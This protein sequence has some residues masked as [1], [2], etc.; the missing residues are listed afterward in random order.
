MPTFCCRRG[1]AAVTT[2]SLLTFLETA[3]SAESPTAP[4]PDTNVSVQSAGGAVRLPPIE[5]QSPEAAPSLISTPLNSNTLTSQQISSWRRQ[6]NDTAR[7]L[8]SVAGASVYSAG[9]VS[10]IPVIQ[11]QAD[12]RLNTLVN[13][14]P[15]PS[16][17]SNHMNPAMSYIDPTNVGTF[18]TINGITPVSKGG[19]SIGGTV[20][21]DSP[22]PVFAAPG[23]TFR[24]AGETAA[25]YRSINDNYAASINN[26]T[27]ANDTFSLSYSGAFTTASNYRGGGDDGKLRST[28]Y[29]AFNNTLSGAARGSSDQF[30]LQLGQQY[31]P[32]QGF[33]NQYMDMT[34]NLSYVANGGYERSFNWGQLTART[35]VQTV[36][37]EMNFLN[38]KGGT[39]GGNGGMPMKTDAVNTGYRVAGL[40]PLNER[41]TLNVGNELY[42]N[43]LDDHWPAVP[44]SMMMGPD[45]YV[46]IND[47]MRTRFG[48]FA[49]WEARWAPQWT[50]LVGVRNDTVWMNTGDVQAYDPVP[51]E[52]NPDA[53]AAA[54]FN[55]RGHARTD[56]NFDATVLGR[57]TA[58]EHQTYE[59]GYAR[60]TRSPNFYERYAWGTGQ[61]ASQMIGWFGDGNGYVGD[62]D[63]KPEVANTVS[64]T[65]DWHGGGDAP[66]QVKVTPYYSYVE[67]YIGVE[68]LQEFPNAAGQPSGFVQLQFTNNDAQFYGIDVSGSAEVWESDD[69]GRFTVFGTVGWVRGQD[70]SSNENAYHQM[71]LN[72]RLTLAHDLDAWSSAVEVIAVA[73][74]S[75]VDNARNELRTSEYALLNLRTSYA[76]G[77]ARLYFGIDNVFD[78]A[79]D[80]PLGG[81]A[82]SQLEQNGGRRQ[83][84][85]GTGRSFIGG[86]SMTW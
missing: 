63:L 62:I 17:C 77:K 9:G 10:S 39:D 73:D 20:V 47:G 35:F 76:L 37:H 61:M 86:L 71:P 30:S 27:V 66:W 7:L 57:F 36:K 12:D 44:G 4:E 32:Y 26:T 8:E 28:E 50:T 11:G 68:R 79:Y 52:M 64:A 81:I 14:M 15:I 21:V 2:L 40:I 69:V 56:V 38:D 33:P 83:E 22:A 6:T 85:W 54:A 42:Y 72:T 75:K 49:E 1:I 3:A 34:E 25:F 19:D 13:G 60:K 80:L 78:T 84:V 74:K 43:W 31:I 45:E 59:L 82:L 65:A 58:D 46:S 51:S 67:N 24:F 53:A 55:A 29:R 18:S 23:E 48:T 16:A 41:D 5:V 70:L